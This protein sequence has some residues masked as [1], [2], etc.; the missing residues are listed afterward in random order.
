MT[1]SRF[2][3]VPLLEVPLT[4]PVDYVGAIGS[5]RT[6]ADRLARLREAG[7]TQQQPAR[8]SAPIGLD[9]GARAPAETAVSIA[10]EIIARQW[11]G[12]GRPLSELAGAMH[13]DPLVGD[14]ASAGMTSFSNISIPEVS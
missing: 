3:D 2:L 11:R 8:L 12:A 4:P 5:R 9:L 13:H 7:L 14:Q 10:A 6:H 1:A